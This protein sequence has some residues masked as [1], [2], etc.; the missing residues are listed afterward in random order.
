MMQDQL[1]TATHAAKNKAKM[2][3]IEIKITA[4]NMALAKKILSEAK[5]NLNNYSDGIETH[6]ASNPNGDHYIISIEEVENA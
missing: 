5:H 4:E 6:S 3:R 1:T 2:I